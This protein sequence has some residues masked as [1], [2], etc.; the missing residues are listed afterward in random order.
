MFREAELVDPGKKKGEEG[1]KKVEKGGGEGRG[2]CVDGVDK[3]S[4]DLIKN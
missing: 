2:K 3:V 4:D 1:K